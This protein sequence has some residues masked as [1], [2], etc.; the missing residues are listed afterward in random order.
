[1][2]TPIT[3]SW[4]TFMSRASFLRDLLFETSKEDDIYKRMVDVVGKDYSKLPD[5]VETAS[6][7]GLGP[8]HKRGETTP[9][10]YDAPGP[11]QVKKS[12]YEDYALAV[13]FTETLIR[14]AQFGIID[15]VVKDLGK[16]YNLSRNLQVGGL[17]DDM[18]TGTTYTGPDGLPL[19]SK[20]H[21]FP[22]SGVTRSNMLA[23][24]SPLSYASASAMLTLMMRQKT[25]RGY[26]MPALRS[27]QRI[28]VVVPPELALEAR[29]IFSVDAGLE[30]G[31]N[32]NSINV[33][34]QDD[35]Q[36]EIVV[37]PYLSS[38]SNWFFVNPDEKGV[39]LV[40]EVPLLD[41]RYEDPELHGVKY[42]VRAAW[43]LHA[44]S[45]YTF[46]GST[47]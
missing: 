23:V 39:K 13:Y 31:V 36:Y 7:A 6:I 24:D 1:M 10:A 42:D 21:T 16:A 22:G 30:P 12:Y 11:G 18:I 44:E 46:Y 47:S 25:P 15:K 4:S 14:R 29:K 35:L 41:S 17:Y 37:N 26:P 43:T 28:L 33:L 34:R 9:F 32:T 38:T 2:S 8:L 19:L 20:V 45:W 27:G 3:T 5:G 40:D